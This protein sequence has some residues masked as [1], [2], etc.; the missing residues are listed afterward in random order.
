MT[1]SGQVTVLGFSEK[2]PHG[3]VVAI[4]VLPVTVS[5][6]PV[7]MFPPMVVTANTDAATAK[8]VPARSAVISAGREE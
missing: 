3:V 4:L 6:P 7:L 1:N 5:V 8:R 2:K